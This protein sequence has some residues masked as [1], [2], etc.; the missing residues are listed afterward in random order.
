MSTFT[1]SP[2]YGYVILAAST[3]FIMHF[4]HIG[5]V[6]KYRKLAKVA[7]PKAYAPESR[8][9]NEAHL[10]NCAQR[11]HSNF[12]ENQVSMLGALMLAGIGFPKTAGALGGAWTVARYLY[13]T[14]YNKGGEGGKGRY[15]GI[16]FWL[17]QAGLVGLAAY[18]GVSMILA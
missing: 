4:V 5:N 12:I 2:D 6:G 13:M 16:W 18:T 3:T 9:D 17:C 10:F 8:T 15:R 1:I 7:Y 11:A 14:G